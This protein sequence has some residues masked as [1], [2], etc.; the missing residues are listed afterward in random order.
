MKRREE[1]PAPPPVASGPTAMLKHAY[2]TAAARRAL[3]QG[4]RGADRAAVRSSDVPQ[5]MLE[6]ASCRRAVCRVDVRWKRE[7]RRAVRER[8]PGAARAVRQR[9]RGRAGGRSSTKPRASS[10][11]T[12]TC[13]ARAIQPAIYPS[14]EG[15]MIE[16]LVLEQRLRAAFPG[17]ERIEVQDLTGTKDH[18]KAVIVAKEFAGQDAH[19]AAPARL[20]GAWRTDGRSGARAGARDQTADLRAGRVRLTAASGVR[21]WLTH[22]DSARSASR[23]RLGRRAE[24]READQLVRG[25]VQ[26]FERALDCA[27]LQWRSTISIETSPSSRMLAPKYS[28]DLACRAPTPAA[29]TASACLPLLPPWRSTVSRISRSISLSCLTMRSTASRASTCCCSFSSTQPICSSC[30]TFLVTSN[31]S[32]RSSRPISQDAVL[33][34]GERRDRAQRLAE[35]DARGAVGQHRAQVAARDALAE[36]RHLVDALHALEAASPAPAGAASS[37]ARRCRRPAA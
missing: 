17:A 15:T 6:R 27:A 28:R 1:E 35:R 10:K 24:H 2:E 8:L 34:V 14:R 20:P 29:S 30:I 7:H 21:R 36:V 4:H 19:R 22:F 13:C 5:G 16:P 12:C 23:G 18:Y 31:S 37:P 32:M 25:A 26:L 9:G 3:G 33:A 11:F